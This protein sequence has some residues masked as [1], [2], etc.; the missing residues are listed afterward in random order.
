MSLATPDY[1]KTIMYKI[2]SKN[3]LISDTYIGHTTNIERRRKHHYENV[4]YPNPRKDYSVYKFIRENGGWENFDLLIIEEYP[5]NNCDEA[6]LRERYWYDILNPSLN[7]RKPISSKKEYCALN[8]DNKREYDIER[9]KQVII[10][11]CGNKIQ[12]ARK[13]EHLKNNH[14]TRIIS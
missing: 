4:I 8:K 3:N 12:L 13:A 11:E 1:S 2:I 6:R 14:K 5:C 7:S 10:C 9:R